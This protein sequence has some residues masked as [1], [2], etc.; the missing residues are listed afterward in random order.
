[1]SLMT[2]A[3][4]FTGSHMVR[5]EALLLSRFQTGPNPDGEELPLSNGSIT[6]DGTAKTRGAG[7]IRIIGTKGQSGPSR[8]PRGPDLS[9]APFGNEVFIRYDILQGS[10]ST[11]STP[12][13]YYRITALEQDN[14]PD[15]P[16]VLFLN[17]RM[18]TIRESRLLQP[19]AFPRGK[20]VE[21]IFN[22][23]VHEIY[24]LAQIVFDDIQGQ[25]TLAR[26]LII[27]RDRY[28]GLADL[29]TSIGKIMFWDDNGILQVITAPE[30]DTIDWEV[31]SGRNG[32]LISARR[33]LTREKVYNAWVVTG[34]AADNEPPAFAIAINNNPNSPTFFGGPFG[35]IPRFY[36]STFINTDSQ[37]RRAAEAGLRRTLGAPF[38]M[39]FE[40]APNPK[41]RP[42]DTIRITYT[43]G[44][45]DEHVLTKVEVPLNEEEPVRAETRE[46]AIVFVTGGGV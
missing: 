46:K 10:G 34:E 31:N 9:I 19:R 40:Q 21:N 36:S 7:W 11:D 2:P 43:D 39:N 25:Q 4:V 16:I 24:P 17:D 13:G 28:E 23:L 22:E 14:A 1:M 29:A 18:S 42:Y 30:E 38:N 41:L 5:F 35:R 37:A 27:E 6:F 3:P 20:T 26:Q 44:S 8:W 45:K 12:L 33:Q 15:R 32:V